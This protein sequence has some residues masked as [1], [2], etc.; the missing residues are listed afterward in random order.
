MAAETTRV[1]DIPTTA[2]TAAADDYV[3][4]DGATNGTRKGLASNLITATAAAATAAHNAEAGAHGSAIACDVPSGVGWPTENPIAPTLQSCAGI[5]TGS[6]GLSAEAMFDRFSTARS[7]PAVSY[8]VNYTTGSDTNNGLATGTAVKSIWK[9]IALANAGGVPVKITVAAGEYPRSWMPGSGASPIVD[10]ALVT[11]GG[12][13]VTGTW[14]PIGTLSADATYTRCYV[15]ALINVERVVDRTRVDRF[16]DY[17]DLVLV[18]SAALCDVTPN[19]WYTDGTTLYIHRL[20]G[21]KPSAANSRVYRAVYQSP[22]TISTTNPHNL[23]V[24]GFDFEGGGS[25]NANAQCTALPS[26]S[27]AFI[28]KNCSLKYAGG[29][30]NTGGCG[31]LAN[32]WHGVV[33]L[34]DCH[35][36]KALRDGFNF[37]NTSAAGAVTY[38]VSVNCTASDCGSYGQISANAFTLHEDCVGIDIAGRYESCRGG[39]VRT[40]GSSRCL[41]LGTRIAGDTGDWTA[42]A[43]T[44]VMV[45]DTAQ[46]W[47]Q[48][49]AVAMPGATSQWRADAGAVILRRNCAVRGID[50]GAGQFGTY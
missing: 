45:S 44:A 32:S 24:D 43:P 19:S 46:L 16:G 29:A 3:L 5:T 18:G 47:A 20:D 10:V 27:V 34:F 25:C 14:D 38:V 8:Y 9:A 50:Q 15:W 41:L 39:T 28:L 6:A 7:A 37:H 36:G 2:T 12:R 33:G 23:Y 49:V 1:K 11:D 17:V 31:L 40:I 30:V 48:A 13:V 42:T 21:A 22:L 4:L 35:A 26:E